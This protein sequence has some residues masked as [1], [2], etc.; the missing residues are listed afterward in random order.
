M[1]WFIGHNSKLRAWKVYNIGTALRPNVVK[2]FTSVIIVSNK[3]DCL[4]LASLSNLV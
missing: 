2:R 1:L 3:L 4:S